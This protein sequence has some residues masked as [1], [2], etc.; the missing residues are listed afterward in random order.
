[1]MSEIVDHRH[2]PRLAP[3]FLPARDAFETR[4]RGLDHFRR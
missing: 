1:M 4:E 2:A 3:H